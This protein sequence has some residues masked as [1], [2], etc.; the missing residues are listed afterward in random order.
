MTGGSAISVWE[1]AVDS[2]H[3]IDEPLR[4][5]VVVRNPK[6]LHMRAAFAVAKL[7]GRFKSN[8]TVRKQERAVNGKSGVSLMTLAAVPGTELVLEVV[9]EDGP[10]A[11]PVL[12]RALAAPSADGLDDLL[13]N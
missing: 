10:A 12:S 3:L 7:A 5:T 2:G 4:T 11:L 1:Q 8:V 6:G 13:R 9:G